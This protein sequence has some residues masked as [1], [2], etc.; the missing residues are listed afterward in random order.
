MD[1]RSIVEQME[2]IENRHA[3]VS[4]PITGKVLEAHARVLITAGLIDL[5]KLIK[6]AT[7]RVPVVIQLIRM[8]KEANHPDFQNVDMEAVEKG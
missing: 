1:W 5:N 7:V 4:L 6:Q 2:I 8:A 3:R